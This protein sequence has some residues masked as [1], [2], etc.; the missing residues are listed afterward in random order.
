MDN[1]RKK[2]FIIS[3][4]MSDGS[5][6]MTAGRVLKF[7]MEETAT[8]CQGSCG[9]IEQAL[10]YSRQGVVLQLGVSVWDQQQSEMKEILVN[11]VKNL[12]FS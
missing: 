6:F 10:A 2:I 3:I 11:T 5:R 4:P 9:Y 8:R 1:I 7:R 12:R